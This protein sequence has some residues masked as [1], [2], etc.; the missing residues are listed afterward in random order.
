ML[1][2]LIKIGEWQSEKM[3]PIERF[4]NKP[5]NLKDNKTY[6]VANLVFDLDEHNIYMEKLKMF[7]DDK[8][9]RDLLL[10]KTLPGNNKAIYATIEK[11]KI[12]NLLKSF[13]GKIDKESLKEVKH[14]ELYLK[15]SEIG[16][17]NN[18]LNVFDEIVKLKDRLVEKI[19]NEDGKLDAK[20]LLKEVELSKGEDISI[21]TTSVISNEQEFERPELIAKTDEYIEFVNRNFLKDEN[22]GEK[23]EEK[24]CYATGDF[25]QDIGELSLET[26]YSLNKMFVTETKNYATVFNKNYFPKNYQV[27]KTNQ[28]FLDIASSYLLKNYKVSIAGIS[29][30]IIPVFL[31]KTDLDFDMI[32]DG[33][34]KKSDFLFSYLKMNQLNTNITGETENLY[35]INYLSIDSDGNYFKSNSQIKDI[36]TPWF[37]KIIKNLKKLNDRISENYNSNIFC[38]F[39]IFYRYI[40][41]KTGINK[42][43][44]LELFRDIFEHRIIDKQIL[45]KYFTKYLIVQRSGQFDNKKNHRAYSNIREQS[46]FDF[47]VANGVMNYLVFLKF[48]KEI[49]LLNINNMEE[50]KDL[51]KSG[52]DYKTRIENFFTDMD[53]TDG[54]KGLFYLGRV[55]NQIAYAQVQSNHSSK[56]VMN[57]LNYNGMDKDAI[58]RLYLD[59]QEKVR[60]YVTKINLNSVEFDFAR[61]TQN[62]NPNSNDNILTPEENVFYILSGYSF[63]LISSG[64]DSETN[65]ENN[66]EK[67]I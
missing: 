23:N 52:S 19:T 8:D 66:E 29:H 7:D 10:L 39:F 28:V 30:V 27:S 31:S 18:Y 50:N 12:N 62:F 11:S 6:Y 60:Q 1:D 13:F 15:A 47:A 48:L 49:R 22:T 45:F 64:N 41:V 34:Y 35:W 56:P 67:T 53:Y 57:K 36:S 55:L 40:P 42:N 16:L 38:N 17:D 5:K 4:L 9:V 2:T 24:L 3:S 14:G 63:G 32:F 51:Q 54:Q 58:L 20:L 26:R 43:E 65:K 33:F 21:I 25:K 61:F 44:A 46:N 59:L 37:V